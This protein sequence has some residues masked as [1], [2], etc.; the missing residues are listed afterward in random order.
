MD[1]RRRALPA[2]DTDDDEGDGLAE[3]EA[4]RDGRDG[5]GW[6]PARGGRTPS[7]KNAGRSPWQATAGLWLGVLALVLAT[8]NAVAGVIMM[9]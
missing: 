2:A 9:S 1:L 4:E 5:D 3:D 7:R 8:V 6:A